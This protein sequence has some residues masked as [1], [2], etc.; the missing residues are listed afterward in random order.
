MWFE[1][2]I[3]FGRIWYIAKELQIKYTKWHYCLISITISYNFISLWRNCPRAQIDSK[4]SNAE[5]IRTWTKQYVKYHSP[6]NE[7]A[8]NVNEIVVKSVFLVNKII[9]K[10]WLNVFTHTYIFIYINLLMK[11]GVKY[12]CQM[13]KSNLAPLSAA[14]SRYMRYYLK[15]IVESWPCFYGTHCVW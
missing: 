2:K 13:S 10:I 14:R 7:M 1:S 3:S 8:N 5:Q 15:Y 6:I 11:T 12:N 9:M 4:L